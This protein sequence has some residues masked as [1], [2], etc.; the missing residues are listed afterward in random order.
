[1]QTRRAPRRTQTAA[2]RAAGSLS[3]RAWAILG[4]AAL[5]AMTTVSQAGAAT[6]TTGTTSA[7]ASRVLQ[8]GA[9]AVLQGT[10]DLKGGPAGTTVGAPRTTTM[11]NGDPALLFNG[12]GQYA[13]FAD[14]AAFKVPTT[15][16]LTVEY[17]M[18]PDAL[19][20]VDQE[21]SG[22][23]YVLGKGD[24][25][26]HEYYGR[27]YSKVN[28]ESRPNR[29]SGYAFNPTG[30]LGAGSY[31]QDS[32]AAGQWIHVAL[33][34]DARDKSSKYPMGYTKIYKNGLLRDTDSLADY[35]ITPRSSSAPFRL[36][37]GYLNSFFQGAVGDVAFYNK[38]LSATTLL[39]H[40][41]AMR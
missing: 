33:V 5:T 29:I 18:R 4:V 10:K 41:N 13:S 20:F 14:R 38:E 40:Y 1:M 34:V 12:R 6:G 8:D 37:T 35:N 16:V 31:F 11:P 9:S 21:G 7:Y 23:V 32:V 3:R 17:W 30:G 28:S 39:A 36:G 22:Y 26:K 19:Q 24:A 15:G 25:G 2:R 27:M